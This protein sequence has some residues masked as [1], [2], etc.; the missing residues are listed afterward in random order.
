MPLASRSL[1]RLS[2]SWQSR[3]QRCFSSCLS[4]MSLV[5]ELELP[6]LGVDREL[7]VVADRAREDPVREWGRWH[8]DLLARELRQLRRGARERVVF[9]GG[10]TAAADQQHAQQSGTG[11]HGSQIEFHDRTGP[12]ESKRRAARRRLAGTRSRPVVS[13]PHA[14]RGRSGARHR[15]AAVAACGTR[16]AVGGARDPAPLRTISRSACAPS[17]RHRHRRRSAGPHR[18]AIPR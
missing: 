11:R 4:T 6:P 10:G 7:G 17:W 16:G 18:P 12:S 8:L 13:A 5:G 15:R 14:R 3:H 9:A 1:S 2:L